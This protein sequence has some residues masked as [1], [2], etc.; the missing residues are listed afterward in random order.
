MG[1][2]SMLK[3]ALNSGVQGDS[4]AVH[5]IVNS[6]NH[7]KVVFS[8]KI[9]PGHLLLVTPVLCH[10]KKKKNLTVAS[11]GLSKELHGHL[12][13]MISPLFLLSMADSKYYSFMWSK[14]SFPLRPCNWRRKHQ[15]PNQ[16]LL[17]WLVL[18]FK[19]EP[20]S[21]ERGSEVQPS[22]SFPRS[23]P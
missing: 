20:D 14:Q 10:T 21:A 5:Q 4:L 7:L 22:V 15:H 12:K 1:T 16:G 6:H 2:K 3:L 19:F 13:W 18:G 11:L 8:I 23:C 17:T 9:P